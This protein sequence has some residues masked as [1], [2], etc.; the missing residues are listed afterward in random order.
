MP[1]DVERRRDEVPSVKAAAAAAEV[2]DAEVELG[3]A[4]MVVDHDTSR[5]ER[6]GDTYLDVGASRSPCQVGEV[7]EVGEVAEGEER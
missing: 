6:E 5:E 7:G 2:D 3:N 4:R 1:D